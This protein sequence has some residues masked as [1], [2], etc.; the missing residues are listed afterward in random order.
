[1][2][3]WEDGKRAAIDGGVRNREGVGRVAGMEAE[4]ALNRVKVNVWAK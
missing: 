3:E 1:M 4:H 2:R